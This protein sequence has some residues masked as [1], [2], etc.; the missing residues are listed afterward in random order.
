MGVNLKNSEMDN[1]EKIE[2]IAD[3]IAPLVPDIRYCECI[4]IIKKLI[5]LDLIKDIND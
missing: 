4:A 2:K 5:E 1:E 3:I